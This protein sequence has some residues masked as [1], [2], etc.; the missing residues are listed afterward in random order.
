[1]RPGN[2]V[3]RLFYPLAMVIVQHNFAGAD[4]AAA[5]NLPKYGCTRPMARCADQVTANK[6]C[7]NIIAKQLNTPVYKVIL[8]VIAQ[9][10]LE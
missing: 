2:M 3:K 5:I 7:R 1:M 10:A 9:A 8:L 6:R 4:I